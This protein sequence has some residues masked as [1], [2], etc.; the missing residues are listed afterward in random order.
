MSGAAPARAAERLYTDPAGPAGGGPLP[1]RSLFGR[2]LSVIA[3]WSLPVNDRWL[4]IACS[5]SRLI[6]SD[7]A[8]GPR[9]ADR[10]GKPAAA[11]ARSR[12]G[13]HPSPVWGLQLET[14]IAPPQSPSGVTRRMTT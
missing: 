8:P 3:C 1:F 13:A 6:M 4:V 10:A 14:P 11:L 12:G 7:K 5:S 9:P 2:C